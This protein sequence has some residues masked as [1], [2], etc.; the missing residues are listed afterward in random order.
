V[1]KYLPG[2]RLCSLSSSPFFIFLG[3][4]GVDGRSHDSN[5]KKH[6]ISAT[7][8]TTLSLKYYLVEKQTRLLQ[9]DETYN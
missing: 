1:I 7:S 3:G 4:E 6:K 2:I 9:L 8:P 5:E